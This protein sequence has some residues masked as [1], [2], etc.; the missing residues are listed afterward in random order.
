VDVE[1]ELRR[2]LL[3]QPVP[4]D[5]EDIVPAVHAG[6]RRRVRRKRLQ[7]VG[8]GAGVLALWAGA[9]LVL[10]PATTTKPQVP[11]KV[12]ANV[13]AGFQIR[14]LTF[15][16]TTRGYGLGTVP[17]GSGRCTV[18][19]QTDT[20]TQQWER[21]PGPLVRSALPDG[22]GCLEGPCVSQIRF[23][24]DARGEEIGYA[25]GPSYVVFKDGEWRPQAAGRRVEALE[26]G[27]AG[28]VVRV[29]AREGGGHYVQQSTVG[30]SSWRTVLAITAPTYNAV[31]RRQGARLVLVTYDNNT[32]AEPNVSDVRFSTDGGTTWKKGAHNPC[33]SRSAFRSIALAKRQHVVVACARRDGGSYVRVSD[34]DGTRFGPARDLPKG[35]EATQ[36]AAPA[37]GGWLVA[38]DVP[39]EHARVVVASHDDGT[40]WDRVATERAPSGVTA[41]GFLD[42]SNATTV[43]WI[44]SDP[45]YVWR[46]DDA[47]DHWTAGR[48]R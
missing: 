21:A 28:T 48:F 11:I 7:Y 47:G 8:A 12:I 41:T 23:A 24:T 10:Q 45:H 19:L 26:A 37:R 1:D 43:W 38:G 15:V 20:G 16:S 4:P 3:E 44:G 42:N 39:D 9:L 34:D 40:T 14:D 30:S 31:L 6:M 27:K 35:L 25:Y 33:D 5:P 46:T 22:T 17:C 18:L 13:P 36:L 32:T 29:L 2:V